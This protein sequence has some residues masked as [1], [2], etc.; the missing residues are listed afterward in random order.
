MSGLYEPGWNDAVMG[1]DNPA[2]N[3]AAVLGGLWQVQQRLGSE[4]LGVKFAAM[5]DCLKYGEAGVAEVIP[6]LEDA[7]PRSQFEAYQLLRSRSEES[8]KQALKQYKFWRHFERIDGLP[9]RHA[10][11]FANRQVVEFES[12][13]AV[14]TPQSIALGLRE[15][16]W[17]GGLYFDERESMEQKLLTFLCSEQANL[18]EAIVFG[19]GS[20][21]DAYGL[22]RREESSLSHLKAIFLGDIEDREMMISS[23]WSNDLSNILNSYPNL[24]ILHTRGDSR[25]WDHDNIMHG[26]LR[27]SKLRHENLLALTIESGGLNKTAVREICNL[28]LPSLEY[29]EIWLGRDEYGGNS[30]ITDLMP[31]ISGE[32]FP[33]LK[34]LGLRNCE[35]SDEIAL[36][37]TQ[38][39]PRPSLIE[40]DLSMGTLT[41][42]GL[43]AMLNSSI[44][45][46]LSTLDVSQCFISRDGLANLM[47][48]NC[49]MVYDRQRGYRSSSHH[50]GRYC[51]VGE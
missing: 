27:F 45:D 38:F 46:N 47:E 41:D 42:T 26:T 28:E 34:Y 51:V 19:N 31:I 40:L 23:I 20:N 49:P 50:S 29:L 3:Q 35:Y 2:P 36:A 30:E 25:W 21:P 7:L 4:D 15:S 24:E 14:E 43:E 12:S 16:R 22:L 10:Q 1:G 48:F 44:L 13:N 18:I 37:L 11:M 9:D 6:F 17:A 39:Q 32:S 33:N 8:I 5:R